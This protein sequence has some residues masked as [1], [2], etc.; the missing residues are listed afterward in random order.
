MV[1]TSTALMCPYFSYQ[2]FFDPSPIGIPLDEL[3]ERAA[4]LPEPIQILGSRLVVHIQTSQE[5]VADLL[6]LI[7]TMASEKRAQGFAPPEKAAA[8]NGVGAGYRD[9][10]LKKG[11]DF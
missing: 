11:R 5:A 4:A 2:I 3:I 1:F 8:V 6:A 9:V 7:Q 10:Y